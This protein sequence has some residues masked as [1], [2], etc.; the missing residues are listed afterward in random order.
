M[1]RIQ[2]D[3]LILLALT[4]MPCFRKGKIIIYVYQHRRAE[5]T[6]L[7]HGLKLLVILGQRRK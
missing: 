6:L 2:R 4:Y 7:W 5:R 3:I 1:R